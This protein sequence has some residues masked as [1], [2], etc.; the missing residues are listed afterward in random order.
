MSKPVSVSRMLKLIPLVTM[1]LLLM[2]CAGAGSCSLLALPEYS[3]AFK[4]D[5][6]MQYAAIPAG[7]PVDRFVLDARALRS[8]VR[9][10]KGAVS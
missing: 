8:A 5:F 10:C 9:A 7:T 3:D 1:T 2:S 6:T 4:A